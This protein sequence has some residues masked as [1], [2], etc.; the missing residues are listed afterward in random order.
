M[1]AGNI[2]LYLIIHI[3]FYIICLIHIITVLS[4]NENLSFR[5]NVHSVRVPRCYR[6]YHWCFL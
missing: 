3:Y 2:Y 4:V 6:G 5:T 1:K